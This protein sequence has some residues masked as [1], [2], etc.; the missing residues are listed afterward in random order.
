MQRRI[1]AAM[2]TDV[3]GIG[4]ESFN[5]SAWRGLERARDQLG[6]EV[7]YLESRTAADYV[8]NL[9]AL[10]RQGFNVVFAIGFLMEDSLAKVAPRFP[11]VYFGIVDGRAPNLPNCVSLIFNEQEGSYLVGALAGAFTKTNVV[12]FVGGMN[13]PLIK[14]FEYGYR[15]GVLTTNPKAKV[16][17]GYTGNWDDVSKGRELALTQFNQGADI[18]YHA[19]GRCGIG[20]IRAAQ[21]KGKGYYA[22]GVDSDQDHLAPGHVLTSMMKRVDNAVFDVCKRVAEGRF[23][24]GTIVY[25]VKEKGVGLSPMRFTRKLVPDA[26]MAKINKLEQLIVQGKVVPPYNEQTFR[27]FRPPQV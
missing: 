26:I 7:R 2:V 19:A 16:L 10:A 1:R 3:G 25:G 23:K 6:A 15:A 22:I 11:K 24:S 27:A 12:G 20:V 14:K 13:V 21:Q 9:T 8:R 18:I 4:D 5:A 17:V